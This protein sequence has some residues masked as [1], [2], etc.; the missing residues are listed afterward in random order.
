MIGGSI[1]Q[2][3]KGL[4]AIHES[5]LLFSR[6]SPQF[7]YEYDPCLFI[8]TKRA[9]RLCF[10][11]FLVQDDTNM[12]PCLLGNL[13]LVTFIIYTWIDVFMYDALYMY[14]IYFGI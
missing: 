1:K 4:N 7:N 6:Q 8:Y 5:S 12:H 11:K 14:C 9:V 10:S 3:V 13:L 2:T